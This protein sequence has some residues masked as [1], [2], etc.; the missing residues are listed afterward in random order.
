MP[1]EYKHNLQIIDL[2]ALKDG[3]SIKC[4][5]EKGASMQALLRED[6]EVW[7]WPHYASTNGVAS[8]KNTVYWND[9]LDAARQDGNKQTESPRQSGNW[10][11]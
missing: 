8:T 9:G 4:E 6:T 7:F 2:N 3:G 10:N 11:F 5:R 1:K